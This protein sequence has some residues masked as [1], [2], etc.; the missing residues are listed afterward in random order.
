MGAAEGGGGDFGEAKVL[1]FA[2]P[3]E[4]RINE[5]IREEFMWAYL[6]NSAIARTVCCEL[7]DVN[8]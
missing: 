8:K 1:D 4:R 7:L 2:L 3:G 5:L 6:T